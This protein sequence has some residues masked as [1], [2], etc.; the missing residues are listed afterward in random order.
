MSPD[1][2]AALDVSFESGEEVL[3]QGAAFYK[4]LKS[5]ASDDDERAKLERLPKCDARFDLLHFEQVTDDEPQP[6]DEMDEMLDPSALL[7]VLDAL[8][9]LTEGVGIDPQSGTLL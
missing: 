1:D 2:Y 6:E 4:E 7:I 3:E 5:S 8:V 9:E